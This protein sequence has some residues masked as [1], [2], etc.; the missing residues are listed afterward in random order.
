MEQSRTFLRNVTSLT[1]ANFAAACI[2]AVISLLIINYFGEKNYG[3]FNTA[4]A[5]ST[6][7][8]I[9]AETGVGAR[10]LYD[11][12]GDKSTIDEHFGAALILQVCPYLLTLIL[13]ISMALVFHRLYPDRYTAVV[14]LLVAIVSGAAVLR[15]FAELCEKVLNVYQEIHLT[16]MLRA[17]RFITIALGGLGVIYF[18]GGLVAWALVWLA[19][20]FLAAVST[21]AASL[22]LARPRF[23]LSTLWPTLSASYIFGI[24]AVFFGIYE[25]VDRPILSKLLPADSWEASVGIYAAAYTLIMFT[26]TLPASLVA[27]LEPIIYGAKED[28]QRLAHLGSLAIRAVGTIALPLA[29]ATLLLAENV[30]SLVIHGYDARAATVLMILA[31]FLFA[32]FMNFPGGMLMAASGQQA[33]RATVQGIAV[34]L[35]IGVNIILIPYLGIF[36]AA[37]TSVLTEWFIFVM[38]Q[39]S[40]MRALPGYGEWRRFGKPVLATAVMAAFILSSKAALAAALGENR[41]AWLV[42]VPPAVGLYFGMLHWLRY[43]TDEERGFIERILSKFMFW[44]RRA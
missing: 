23:V 39:T 8:L 10:F 1:S 28:K 36:G 13:A 27:S 5:F 35:N 12:S 16:A 34:G 22:R 40:V 19:V 29:T 17:L 18:H 14:V 42:I 31:P 43:F 26:S 24:G 33:R 21:F 44:R 25:Y 4:M 7:F 11:R 3:A 30:R 2:Q 20:M 15:V 37:L 9:C 32:K 6:V 41:V 38:Y